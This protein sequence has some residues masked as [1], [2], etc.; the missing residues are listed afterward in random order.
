ML[1]E[2]QSIEIVVIQTH[3]QILPAYTEEEKQEQH[4][5]ILHW[6]NRLITELQPILAQYFEVNVCYSTHESSIETYLSL[7][8]NLVTPQL[9]SLSSVKSFKKSIG[10]HLL[11]IGFRGLIIHCIHF[12]LSCFIVFLEE[13]NRNCEFFIK[14]FVGGYD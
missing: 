1:R 9:I 11:S 13:V 2:L 14:L 5:V 8:V 6:L 7:K 12:C 4:K 10:T 3:F